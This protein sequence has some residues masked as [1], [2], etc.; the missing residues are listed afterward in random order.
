MALTT[1]DLTQLYYSVAVDAQN[2][3]DVAQTWLED[4]GLL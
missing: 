4:N 1:D 3:A 2:L